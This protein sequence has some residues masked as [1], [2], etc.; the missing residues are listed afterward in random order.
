MKEKKVIIF[1]VN[2]LCSF[3]YVH[4]YRAL[5]IHDRSG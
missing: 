4:T 2:T 5:S 3:D 1:F